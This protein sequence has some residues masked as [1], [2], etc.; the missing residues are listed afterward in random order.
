MARPS[1]VRKGVDGSKGS[2]ARRNLIA[3]YSDRDVRSRFASPGAPGARKHI[4]LVHLITLL[5]VT[6][7]AVSC[8]GQSLFCQVNN[9]EWVGVKQNDN[10]DNLEIGGDPFGG[11]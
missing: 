8:G 5:M 1:T 2:R 11:D 10:L 4:P 3:S 9:V 7:S 6:P